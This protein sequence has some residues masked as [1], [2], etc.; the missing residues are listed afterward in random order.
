MLPLIENLQ[1]ALIV[2]STITYELF[3]LSTDWHFN[4]NY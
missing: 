4:M 2:R 1:N 3:R